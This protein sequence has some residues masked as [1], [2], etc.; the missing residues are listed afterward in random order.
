MCYIMTANGL[1]MLST[2]ESKELYGLK[3]KSN[4][5]LRDKTKLK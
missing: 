4:K 2:E 1:I 3:D 5:P